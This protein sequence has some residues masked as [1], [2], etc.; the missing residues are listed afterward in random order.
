[1][2]RTKQLIALLL[3]TVLVLGLAA[4]GGGSAG[5]PSPSASGTGGEAAPVVYRELYVM[6]VT[7]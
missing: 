6:E 3:A 4:C 7:R 5:S 1:M 2:K